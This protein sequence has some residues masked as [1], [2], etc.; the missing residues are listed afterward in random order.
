MNQFKKA[1]ITVMFAVCLSK[2]AVMPAVVTSQQTPL[3]LT[4]NTVETVDEN[5]SENE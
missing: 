4:G 1:M 3:L 5:R 2:G